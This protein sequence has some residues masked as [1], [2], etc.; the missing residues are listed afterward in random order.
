MVPG[1]GARTCAVP[2]LVAASSSDGFSLPVLV[3]AG[4]VAIA[5][6]AA[7]SAVWVARRPPHVDGD[8]P[9]MELGAEPPAVASLLCDDYEVRPRP[10][11][12]R[13]SIS[14]PVT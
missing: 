13:C 5:W 10:R 8:P 4:V 9:T 1:A 14:R 2:G 7:A 6:L 3:A 12:R 11:R